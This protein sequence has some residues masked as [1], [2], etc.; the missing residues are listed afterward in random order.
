MH[1]FKLYWQEV[2]TLV[3]RELSTNHQSRTTTKRSCSAHRRCIL[4]MRFQMIQWQEVPCGFVTM[5]S[6]ISPLSLP[7]LTFDHPLPLFWHDH[8]QFYQFLPV[9]A[10]Q[11]LYSFIKCNNR[12]ITLL[13]VRCVYWFSF[14]GVIVDAFKHPARGVWKRDVEKMIKHFG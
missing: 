5:S 13:W 10:V 4:L 9:S 14:C 3:G 7:L 6:R 11:F 1:K 8:L 2:L 12:W